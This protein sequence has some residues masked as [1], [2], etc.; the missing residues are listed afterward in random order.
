MT[1]KFRIYFCEV[2]SINYVTSA[3]VALRFDEK[4]ANRFRLIFIRH[5]PQKSNLQ[6][7]SDLNEQNIALISSL[8]WTTFPTISRIFIRIF[9]DFNACQILNFHLQVVLA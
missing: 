6:T 2:K 1:V 4:S 5:S 7:T 3:E 8:I 9:D